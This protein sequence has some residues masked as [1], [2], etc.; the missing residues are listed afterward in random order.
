MIWSIVLAL[1]GI[2]GLL[3]AGRERTRLAGWA[4]GWAAQVLWVMYALV[5]AQYGFLLSAFAY[6]GV[7]ARNALLERRRRAQR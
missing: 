3:L 5:T 2:T 1:V 7:Y 6:G 4:V